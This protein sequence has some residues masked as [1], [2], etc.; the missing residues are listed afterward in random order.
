MKRYILG[1]TTL[2]L[3]LTGAG[4]S[5]RTTPSP[6]AVQPIPAPIAAPAPTPV[7]PTYPEGAMPVR[8]RPTHNI[9]DL[10]NHI[11]VS[12]TLVNAEFTKNVSVTGTAI[13]FENQFYWEARNASGT[14]LF[15][16]TLM[17][18]SPDVGQ[19]GPFTLKARVPV[20]TS[21]PVTLRFY[22][23][24]AKDG[25]ATNILDVPVTLK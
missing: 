19:P 23:A 15:S 1:P 25:S 18:A 21:T 5:I 24:F 7:V 8:P 14:A 4:C 6:V 10:N 17:A 22:E 11:C 9:C 12:E 20:A 3:L 13:A 16:G 2:A